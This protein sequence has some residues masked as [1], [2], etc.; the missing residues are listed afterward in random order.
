MANFFIQPIDTLWTFNY[1][2]GNPAYKAAFEKFG[3]CTVTKTPK[4]SVLVKYDNVADAKCAVEALHDEIID[5][6]SNKKLSVDYA[7][8]HLRSVTARGMF[9]PSIFS[10]L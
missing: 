6:D 5:K 7:A 1:V 4:G 8:R 9:C 2:Y 3:K 10:D